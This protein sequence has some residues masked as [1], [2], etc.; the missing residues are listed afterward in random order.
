[1][2]LEDIC[3]EIYPLTIVFDR[4]SGAYSGG[5]FT[6]WNCNTEDVP[7]AIS[8]D[9]VSCDEFWETVD[10]DSAQSIKF[11]VGDTVIEAVSDLLRKTNKEDL[12]IDCVLF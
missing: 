3:D 10:N 12:T 8:S 5:K 2:T 1:M 4:Y 9:D 7:Q 11:G 6:A